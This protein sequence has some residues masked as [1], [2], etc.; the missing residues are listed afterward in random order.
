VPIIKAFSLGKTTGSVYLYPERFLEEASGTKI[1]RKVE[2]F[3]KR[4]AVFRKIEKKES[5]RYN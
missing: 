3:Y 2:Y 5:R 1:S 4:L